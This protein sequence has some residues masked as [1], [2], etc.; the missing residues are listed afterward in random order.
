MLTSLFCFC[1]LSTLS[2]MLLS[3]PG[4]PFRLPCHLLAQF[5]T[6]T[7]MADVNSQPWCGNN[8]NSLSTAPILTMPAKTN[9]AGGK[10]VAHADAARDVRK[11]IPIWKCVPS[12][13]SRL[14]FWPQ[15]NRDS[16]WTVRLPTPNMQQSI[17]AHLI[18]FPA[19]KTSFCL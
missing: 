17:T 18:S 6:P 19:D 11:A 3:Y 2:D 13:G 5:F 7:F 8:L 15:V 12:F 4:L 10:K 14:T 9:S 16:G 1:G